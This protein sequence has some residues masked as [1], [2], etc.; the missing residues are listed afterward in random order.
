M[1]KSP[2][3]VTS[4]PTGRTVDSGPRDVQRLVVL[5]R[6]VAEEARPQ[7]M[8]LAAA[9][10]RRRSR[11]A[12]HEHRLPGARMAPVIGDPP[13]PP[14]PPHPPTGPST[15]TRGLSVESDDLFPS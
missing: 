11:E 14:D 3:A 5:L 15:S 6:D 9:V 2:G 12:G 7:R 10:A 13:D 1:P 8:S 4:H